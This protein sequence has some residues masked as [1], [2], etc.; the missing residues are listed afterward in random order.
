M[1]AEFI[2]PDGSAE[3]QVN[4]GL[5]MQGGSSTGGWKVIKVSM[6]LLFKGDYG[7]TKLRF[8]LFPDSPVEQFDTIVLDA[9]MNQTWQ[10][11]NH[12]QRVKGQYCRDQYVSDLQNAMGGFA[13]HDVFYH[14]YL[15]GLYWGVFDL[16]ERPDASFAAEYFGGDKTEYDSIRH[17]PGNVVDGSS[18]AYNQLLSAARRDLSS[19]A[20]YLA[21]EDFLDVPRLIDYMLVNIYCGNDDWAHHNWYATRHRSVGAPYLF[22]SWDAEHVL[23]SVSVNRVG[24]DNS[25]APT[26]IYTNL[27]AND[28]FRLLFAD[29]VHRH[30]FN[31]GVLHVDPSDPDWDPTNPE[32]N[33]PAQAWMRRI[34]ELDPAIA[35]E[36]ARWGDTRRNPPYTRNNEWM[37]ELNNLLRNYFP[38]RSSIVLG[39]LRSAG[40]YPNV[41]APVFSQHGGRIEPGFQLTMT[42]S[43]TG[44]IYYTTNGTDPRAF[45]SGNIAPSAEAYSDSVPI[46]DHTTVLARV[47]SGKHLERAHRSDVHSE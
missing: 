8:P 44:A 33:R 37:A 42:R 22:H 34:N 45:G 17:S 36:A 29:H 15:N 9:H 7:A 10:H 11:P 43:G 12:G 26:E 24:A 40:L 31:G 19:N 23:K 21:L 35:C 14:V 39:Q 28:E 38:D 30:F 1:S 18:T 41:N 16:H 46:D 5:R 3:H 4:C 2:F 47:R 20:N 25:G 6:R 13:V 32:R 27:R